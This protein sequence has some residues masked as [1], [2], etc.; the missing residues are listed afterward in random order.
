METKHPKLDN[1]ESDDK[2]AIFM[3]KAPDP[4]SIGS[5]VGMQLFIDKVIGCESKVFY[6]GEI[7]HPENKALMNIMN[8]SFNDLKEFSPDEYDYN[9]SVDCTESNIGFKDNQKIKMDMIIDHHR[10]EVEESEY[11]CVILDQIGSASSLVY[12]YFVKGLLINNE[13]L[14]Q[15][16]SNVA[17][18]LLFGIIKDTDNLLENATD[19]DFSAHRELVKLANKKDIAEIQKY[20]LPDYIFDLET[21]AMKNDNFIETSATFVTFLGHISEA[22]RDILP[23]LADKYMRKENVTT[24]IVTAVVGDSLGASI[25]STNVSIDVNDFAKKVFG[26]NHAGGKRGIG[27]AT[28]PLDKGFININDEDIR[29]DYIQVIKKKILNIIK[30]EVTKEN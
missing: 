25:R 5:A 28:V 2:V 6:S 27:G 22:K 16:E 12:H 1:L 4:D 29:D 24:S 9:I 19:K 23:Y 18:C 10:V 20:P 17:T 14:E 26:E 11:D 30:K 3:H 8:Y 13:S 15:E 21:V 7:S